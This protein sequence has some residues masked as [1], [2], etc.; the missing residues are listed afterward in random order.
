M[1]LSYMD[2]LAL[3][4]GFSNFIIFIISQFVIYKLFPKIAIF[5]VI[6]LSEFISFLSINII[7]FKL[8]VYSN[9]SSVIFIYI[10]LTTFIISILLIIIYIGSVMGIAATSIRIRILQEIF[11]HG[12]K[13]ISYK[14]LLK[15]YNKES[16]IRMR[17]IRLITAGEINLHGYKYKINKTVSIFQIHEKFQLILRNVF[18][19]F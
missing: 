17:I 2:N 14:N 15:I 4:L 8:L 12:K 16:I 1:W 9:I 10:Y 19:H 18:N 3:F 5:K 7:F 11:I 6:I 13:G